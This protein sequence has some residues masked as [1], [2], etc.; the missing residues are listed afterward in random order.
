M[1]DLYVLDGTGAI[2]NNYLGDVRVDA[3]FTDAD[4]ATNLFVPN[5]GAASFTHVDDPLPDG[6]TT[7]VEAGNI[8]DRDLY[9]VDTASLGTV[10]HGIQQNVLARK[11]DAGTVTVDVISEKP[12]GTGEKVRNTETASDNYKYHLSI[13][14]LDPDD[15]TSW[16]DAKVNATE[17]GFKI[18]NIVT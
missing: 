6:D 12:S 7:F 18:N 10:I 16:N 8:A 1:D 15:N 9:S 11:T 3:E 17:F 2:N 13:S 14:E 5:T 4:G